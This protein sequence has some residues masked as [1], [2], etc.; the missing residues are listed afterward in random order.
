MDDDPPGLRT[1]GGDRVSR[2]S[3]RGVGPS[4]RTPACL[5][6]GMPPAGKRGGARSTRTVSPPGA[7]SPALPPSCYL[8]LSYLSPLLPPRARLSTSL[9]SAFGFYSPCLLPGPFLLLRYSVPHGGCG[10]CAIFLLHWLRRRYP[11][12]VRFTTQQGS[13]SGAWFLGEGASTFS[14]S[15]FSV[16]GVLMPS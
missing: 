9:L 13:D 2:L 6:G 7:S 10:C 16:E 3:T 11:G 5:N 4:P 1:A 15:I 8:V 14:A 12:R